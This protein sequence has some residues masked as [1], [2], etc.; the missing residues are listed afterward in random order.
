MQEVA[1]NKTQR[2]EIFAWTHRK[3]NGV[4]NIRK[5]IRVSMNSFHR[6]PNQ[7]IICNSGD[8]DSH[9][10]NSIKHYHLEYVYDIVISHSRPVQISSKKYTQTRGEK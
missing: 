7:G 5:A 10:S 9:V 3:S 4:S 8:K 2:Q 6:A 1:I